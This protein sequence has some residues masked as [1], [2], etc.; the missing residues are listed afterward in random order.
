MHLRR[1]VAGLGLLPAAVLPSAMHAAAGTPHSPA[2]RVAR[3]EI[4]LRIRHADDLRHQIEKTSDPS[5]SSYGHVLSHGL[6][7]ARYGASRHTFSRL[8]AWLTASGYSDVAIAAD[9]LFVSASG[10]SVLPTIP[11]ALAHDVL[12]VVDT[13]PDRGFTSHLRQPAPTRN[14]ERGCRAAR[15]VGPGDQG[16]TAFFP[17]RRGDRYLTLPRIA[18]AYGLPRAYNRGYLGRGIEVD[19][20]EAE[21]SFRVDLPTFDRCFGLRTHITYRPID[22]GVPDAG[23]E[24]SQQPFV[25]LETAVDVETIAS[26]APK[27]HIVVYQGPNSASGIIHTFAAMVQ[28]DRA[29]I[30]SNS[31]GGC[32]DLAPT[33]LGATFVRSLHQILEQAAAQGQTV[34]AASGDTGAEDCAASFGVAGLDPLLNPIDVQAVDFPASDPNTLAVGGTRLDVDDAGD[35]VGEIVWNDGPAGGPTARFAGGGGPSHDFGMSA[36]Q[37]RTVSGPSNVS[38]ATAAT[39]VCPAAAGVCRQVP[40]VAAN[41]SFAT[42]PIV[43]WHGE[44]TDAGGTSAASPEWAGLLA[45]ANS[46]A[47]QHGRRIGF[48]PPLLYRIAR[49]AHSYREAFL[50]VTRGN[51]DYVS[52]R[53]P[54]IG[55]SARRGF[56]QASG[57]GAPRNRTF[58]SGIVGQLCRLA[59]SS[60]G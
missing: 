36:W 2:D 56:D 1:A 6:F 55:Y 28:S 47:V 19:V 33:A 42:G 9:R 50:D 32:E 10:P 57:L 35:R 12:G 49:S 7:A 22:G 20:F 38:D 27:A 18:G 31:F 53:R 16:R 8:T 24:V 5:S 29:R 21:A 54:V 43:Y 13:A 45:V 60:R 14:A 39:G 48:V 26:F 11:A 30:I 58:H 23:G 25:G 4:A 40:D 37:R 46:C 41:A 51:N 34:T 44:W 17:G 52:P 3:I 59:P 15:S